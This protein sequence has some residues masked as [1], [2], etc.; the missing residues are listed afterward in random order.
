MSAILLGV[1]C[2]LFIGLF[3][4]INRKTGQEI[5]KEGFHTWAVVIEYKTEFVRVAGSWTWLAY[6]QVD[7]ISERG[8]LKHSRLKYASSERLLLSIGDEIEV[9]LHKGELY[10]KPLFSQS[11]WELLE[12]E[13]F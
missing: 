5:L 12:G 8:Q 1:S 7:Y 3:L 2:G 11:L 9:V 6:P 4:W 13:T 10:F